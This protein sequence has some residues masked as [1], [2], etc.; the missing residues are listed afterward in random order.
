MPTQEKHKWTFAPRFRARAFGWKSQPAI[1]RVREAVSEIKKAAK[2]EPVLAAEGAVLF[3][4][5][6]SPAIEQVDGSSGGMGTAV[7]H[8]IEELVDVIA[9]APAD[10]RT[11]DRWLERLFEA[12]QEDHIPYIESLADYWGELCVTRERAA[13][14]ADR[15][16][17][18]LKLSWADRCGYFKGT[19]ACLSSLLAAGR[20]VELLD[21]LEAAPHVWWHYRRFGVR[22]LAAMDRVDEAIAYA[23][24]SVGL[25]DGEVDVAGMCESILLEAGRVE[26]AYERFAIAASPGT[27]R[28]ATFRAIAKKYPGREKTRILQDLIDST[29]GEE[30]KWFATARELGLLDLAVALARE[31]PCDPKTLNRAGRDHLATDPGFA[32]N[33]SLLSLHWIARGWGY[34]I[35]GLDV[36][37][38]CDNALKGARVAGVYEEVLA[39][40]EALVADDRSAGMFVSRVLKTQLEA[41]RRRARAARPSEA[42]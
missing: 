9:R 28:L 8:A 38:A 19:P 35:T 29:P 16:L 32:V 23:E 18:T 10:D 26:E 4:E 30:G 39:R 22:A 27:N 42:P 41:E 2:K 7:S 36:L 1:K 40:I 20:H 31:S 17:P 34:E 21:L 25:N 24:R 14:W 11:R 33:V 13:E 5:R 15:L 12:L 6:V 37:E 3:L